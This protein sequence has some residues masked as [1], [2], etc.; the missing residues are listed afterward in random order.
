[1]Q[2]RKQK[3][4][5]AKTRR[6]SKYAK[7]LDKLGKKRREKKN[8]LFS[9]LWSKTIKREFS[10]F[11]RRFRTFPLFYN[12]TMRHAFKK[13]FYSTGF[14]FFVVFL[15]L[16]EKRDRWHSIYRYVI[17][18][19]PP[20]PSSLSS[21]LVRH[22]QPKKPL[23]HTFYLATTTE[24]WRQCSN[25]RQTERIIRKTWC[26]EHGNRWNIKSLTL[27]FPPPLVGTARHDSNNAQKKE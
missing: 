8:I 16:V 7:Q 13:S 25:N 19:S 11:T 6:N 23:L 12:A 20:P 9:S 17:K 10:Y 1:M 2:I 18:R 27:L 5:K 14:F 26:A 3:L 24:R 21:P 4:L 15:V 22:T